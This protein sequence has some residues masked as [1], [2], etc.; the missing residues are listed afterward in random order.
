MT[1]IT[2]DRRRTTRL[3]TLL[4]HGIVSV[5]IRA[6]HAAHVIDVSALGALLETAHRMLPGTAVDLHFATQRERTSIRARVIR[7]AVVGVRPTSLTYRGA[8]LFDRQLPWFAVE[9]GGYAL[10]GTEQRA[11]LPERAHATHVVA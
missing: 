3:L 6:G 2:A 1:D 10:P 8:V 9:E 4:D 5:R 11:A 7:C